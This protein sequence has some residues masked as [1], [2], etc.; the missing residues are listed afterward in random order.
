MT[1]LQLRSG[2][3]PTPEGL[4]VGDRAERV[5]ALYGAGEERNGFWRYRQDGVCLQILLRDGRVAGI[6]YLEA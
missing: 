4:A 5:E 1:D 3:A 6:R 2:C